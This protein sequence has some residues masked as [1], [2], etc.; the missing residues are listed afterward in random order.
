MRTPADKAADRST[1]SALVADLVD[2]RTKLRSELGKLPAPA[3]RNAVQRR[4]ALLMR[5]VILLL[6]SQLIGW[7]AGAAADRDGTADQ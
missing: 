4:D 1:A 7:G 3:A 6:R 2:V 5:A